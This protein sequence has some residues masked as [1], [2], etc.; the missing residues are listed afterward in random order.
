[1]AQ[2]FDL[3][4]KHETASVKAAGS[5]AFK[6]QPSTAPNEDEMVRQLQAT[7]R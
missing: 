4:V 3:F 6:R 5:S 7:G 2:Q 1:M